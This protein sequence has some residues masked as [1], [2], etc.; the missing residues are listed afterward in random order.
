MIHIIGSVVDARVRRYIE[1]NEGLHLRDLLVVFEM[2]VAWVVT[3]AYLAVVL[4]MFGLVSGAPCPWAFLATR[5][6][7]FFA[8]PFSYALMYLL[9]CGGINHLYTHVWPEEGRRL[10][11][12]SKRMSDAEQMK[13][14][15]FSLKS[16]STVSAASGFMYYAIQG[17]TNIH[18]GVPRPKELFWFALGYILVDISAYL[19]HRMLH[20]PWWYVRVHKVHHLWKS[21]NVFV[22]S[23][24]HPVEF[25]LLTVPTLAILTA[26]PLSFPIFCL[27]LFWIFLCNSIDHSGLH[28]EKWP[29]CRLMFWQ[30]HPEFHDNHHAFFQANY[31]AMVDWWD[32]L[33]GTYYHPKEHGDI[34]VREG[35]FTEARVLRRRSSMGL[36][37]TDFVN[38]VTGEQAKGG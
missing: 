19:V 10:S 34:G 9:I 14:I 35:E 22:V 4:P 5:A 28:L 33:G 20:R 32:R 8:A 3:E 29:L 2:S 36:E 11:I 37:K 24:L 17:W 38:G 15:C 23:A 31:G 21:P 13:A 7:V 1:A 18:W 30:A 27:M 12:Q 16:V 26:L 25:L 6:V